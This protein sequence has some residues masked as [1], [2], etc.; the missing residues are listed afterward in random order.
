VK[1][2]VQA[3]IV[4][5]LLLAGAP[6]FAQGAGASGDIRGRVL[7]PNGHAIS[8]ATVTVN[9]RSKGLGRTV[10]TDEGGEYRA[11]ALPP[12]TYELTARASGFASQVQ[13]QVVVTVG[14]TAHVDFNLAL[15]TVATEVMVTAETAP[16]EVER[17]QQSNTIVERYIRDLP[18]DR[19]DYLT[20]TLLM[21]GVADANAMADNSDFRVPQ[22]PHSGLSFYGSN[23]RGNSVTVDGAEA[24]DDSGGVRLTLSQEAVQEFQVN[25]SNYSAEFGGASGAVINIVSKSGGRQLHGS[26][27]GFFRDTA[28][29][30]RDPFALASALRPGDPFRL[31]ARSPGPADAA[32]NRQQVGGT[33]G[34]APRKDRIF[35]F[36]AYEHLRRNESATVPLLTNTAI[37]GPTASQETILAGLGA[38]GAC[39][40]SVLTVDPTTPA[41][42]FCPPEPAIAGRT[43]PFLVNLFVSNSGNFPF[44]SNSHLGSARLDFRL[45]DHNQAFFRY[46]AG[47][48]QEQNPNL[49]ALVGYS[50]GNQVHMSDNTAVAGWFR[51]FGERAQNEARVMVNSYRLDVKPND[52]LGPELNL[53][54]FGF[55]NRDIL[56]PSYNKV[57]HY[58]AADNFTWLKGNHKM[59][60]GGYLLLRD[61]DSEAHTFFPGRFSFGA[62]PGSLVSPALAGTSLTA[63][64]A[65]KLG[66]PQFYQQGFGDP[67]FKKLLPFT[68]F[69]WQDSWSRSGLTLN[70]GLR[71]ERDGR[72]SP[73]PTDNNNFAPRVGFSW[74]PRRD[75]KTVVRGGYGLFYS[76]I[77]FQLDYIVRAL[78]VV[79][80][81]RQ[82][83]QVFVPLTGAPGNPTLTSAAIFQRLL[84]QQVIGCTATNV[85]SCITPSDLAQFGIAITH[86]GPVPPLSVLFSGSDRF[87]NPYAQQASLGIERQLLPGVFASADYIFSRTLKIPRARD[88]NVLPGGRFANPLLLQDNFYESAGQAQ[89]HG[90]AV[91]VQASPRRFLNLMANYTFSKA[92][93]DVTDYNSP[94][95]PSDQNN[96]R[97][98]RALSSFD[99]RH[100]AVVAAILSSPHPGRDSAWWQHAT[101]DSTLSFIL[102]ANSGR[103]FN[104]LAGTDLNGDRH[105]DTDRP[106]GVG[107]NAGHGPNFWT[108]DLRVERRFGSERRN[109]EVLA[110]FFNLANRLN[111]SSVNNVVGPTFNPASGVEGRR[112]RSPSEPLGF[113]AAFAPRRIQLGV[114]LNF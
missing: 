100:K 48:A 103:P 34:F 30:A 12:A 78:G 38:A 13:P 4:G 65:F 106:P 33:L 114:R 85:E 98:E 41:P 71:Y 49:A 60:F 96:L 8:G 109:L 72:A 52:P 87:V 108:L 54:G 107:R 2:Q 92:I 29:D 67:L 91:Q 21:P 51:Q 59:K 70:F 112:D 104:L 43:E 62:L 77:Y 56:L 69:Y 84:A 82:V 88:K 90:L 26:A 27:Y 40:R 63:L 76:P 111:F 81:F 11:F 20:F 32:S 45:N 75:R 53:F 93:D 64:Q 28:L 42:S 35:A 24:N 19:R 25:R 66:L 47:D 89:Y 68:A 9:D 22:T 3:L 95:Q 6:S 105:S 16:M 101:G 83:A 44:S 10:V 5:A 102:R 97:A 61:I 55:F 15:P 17:T 79:D 73:L 46:S 39:L 80:G 113:T 7:D 31:D 1:A 94:F 110:E 18:I 14:A 57:R 36:L 74:D 50:R 37:F 23:G 86:T 99:Q 58:E